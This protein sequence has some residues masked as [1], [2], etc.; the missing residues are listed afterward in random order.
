MTSKNGQSRMVARFQSKRLQQETSQTKETV[1][2]KCDVSPQKLLKHMAKN[3]KKRRKSDVR[4]A[5]S[6]GRNG[7]D[8]DLGE[9]V[10]E[11]EE[12]VVVVKQ[13]GR[14]SQC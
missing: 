7:G 9:E 3:C 5:K 10:I 12:V 11:E 4:Q 14:H 1:S 2:P 8:E 13:M 6:Q